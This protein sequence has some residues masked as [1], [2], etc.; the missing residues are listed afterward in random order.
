MPWATVGANI[1]LPLELK[2]EGASVAMFDGLLGMVGLPGKAAGDL[3]T[4]SGGQQMRVSIARAL[5]ARPSLLLLDEPFAA[6][7][8]MLR[9]QMNELLLRLNAEQGWGALFVTHSLYE[10][11]YLCDRV[12]IMRDG[13]AAGTV[14]PELDRSLPPA[15]QRSSAP[16]MKAVGAIGA[17]MAQEA[18]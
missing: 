5:A 7:D 11:A 6:L 4:L 14:T 2:G 3:Q 15:E 10:A 18:A 16:F 13:M 17:L 8:E 12:I 9:F 1:A